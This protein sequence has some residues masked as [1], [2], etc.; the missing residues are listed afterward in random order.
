M[1]ARHRGKVLR[2]YEEKPAGISAT[3]AGGGTMRGED[4]DWRGGENGECCGGKN[5]DCRGGENGD[6]RGSESG[7]AGDGGDLK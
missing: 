6:C 4:G 5:G 7:G 1:E 3:F 2:P